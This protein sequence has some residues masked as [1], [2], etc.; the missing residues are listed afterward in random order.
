MYWKMHY[1]LICAFQVN[2]TSY[3]APKISFRDV[4]EGEIPGFH[5]NVEKVYLPLGDQAGCLLS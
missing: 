1:F 5:D 2:V 4:L 3:N